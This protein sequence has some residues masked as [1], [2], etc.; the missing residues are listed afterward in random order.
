MLVKCKKPSFS[1][2][3]ISHDMY[4]YTLWITVL[5]LRWV[6]REVNNRASEAYPIIADS[7]HT[8]FNFTLSYFS[9][10]SI[11]RCNRRTCSLFWCLN[12]FSST[13]FHLCIDKQNR[14][15]TCN[16]LSIVAWL[17]LNAWTTLLW[18]LLRLRT[19]NTRTQLEYLLQ[20][21]VSVAM[22][23]GRYRAVTK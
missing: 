22:V 15:L 13:C 4:I 11:N 2:S 8:F 23:T 21:F 1:F 17:L 18:D 20:L 19:C 12:R 5:D 3:R 9:L 7:L 6:Y 16:L 10:F 14:I